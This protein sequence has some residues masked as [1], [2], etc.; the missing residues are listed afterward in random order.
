MQE[1]AVSSID[2]GGV[3]DAQIEQLARSLYA[4][5][6]SAVYGRMGLSTQRHGSLCQWLIQLINL[7]TGQLD[8]VGG[9]LP[10]RTAVPVIGPATSRGARDR[11]RSRVRGLPEFS[12]EL[13]VAA[14]AEEIETP[15]EG[16]I[17][18]LLTVAGNPVL[19]TPQ[20]DRLGKALAQ[21]EFMV[22]IDIYRNETTRHADLILP[23]ASSLTQDHYDLVFNA[24]AV[25]RVA[26]LSAAV[27]TRA[28]QQRG[29]WEIFNGLAAAFASAAG[30]SFEPPPEPRALLHWLLQGGDSGVDLKQLLGA[31]HGLDLGPLE[32]CLPGLIQHADKQ[33][34][35]AP[36]LLLEALQIYREA[37]SQPAAQALALIGRREVRDNNS[38]MHNLPRLRKGSS[39][40]ALWMHPD[41]LQARQLSDGA[42]VQIRSAVGAVRTVVRAREDLLPGVVCL[43][44]GYGHQ[45]SGTAQSLAVEDPGVSYNDLSDAAVLDMPTGN[46]A[47][48]GTP[49]W[50][51]AAPEAV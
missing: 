21:L 20:G 43:P 15:G 13:P 28:A 51:E 42:L 33:I 50:V 4:A 26:R 37:S 48:N 24:F 22:A 3:S 41:D 10:N 39:R 8:R 9:V 23:P 32:P 45:A 49:V 6:R 27:A 14:L 19:S 31:P 30:K 12:G 38:W 35:C 47:L 7:Y 25:R 16:Q 2:C 40:H 1:M 11:W 18:A 5:Q 36:P 17:R 46:A 34:Q 29:D 44:H